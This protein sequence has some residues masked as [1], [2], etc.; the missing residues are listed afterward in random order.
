MSIVN[1]NGQGGRGPGA[2]LPGFPKT[3]FMYQGRRRP[4]KVGIRKDIEAALGDAVDAQTA[5]PSAEALRR[6]RLLPGQPA[7]RS[8]ADRP[9]RRTCR[10]GHRGRVAE[11]QEGHR[12]AQ[13][14]EEGK[15]EAASAKARTPSLLC[16]RRPGS[17]GRWPRLGLGVG[18]GMN[19]PEK[20]ETF[21][22]D[23]LDLPKAL[24]PLKAKPNWVTWK[25]K[26]VGADKKTGEDKWTK[27]PCQPDGGVAAKTDDP[28]TWGSYEACVRTVKRGKVDGIG[29][30][31]L[32][33]GFAAFDVDKCRD[34]A[35]GD[36]RPYAQELL[37]RCGDTY[38]E[39][40]VSGT[41]IRII[42]SSDE[43]DE[44]HKKY[45]VGDGV[46]VELY[47]KATRYITVSGSVLPGHDGG[48]KNIDAQID[49]VHAEC[50]ARKKQQEQ[51]E[52]TKKQ[53]KPAEDQEPLTDLLEIEH[54]GAGVQHGKYSSRNA[55]LFGFLTKSIRKKVDDQVMID[56]CLDPKYQGKAIYEHCLENGGAKY[57]R[58]QIERAKKTVSDSFEMG[59]GN[60]PKEKSQHN[61]KLALAK[62]NVSLRYDEF[63]DS[64]LIDGLKGHVKMIDAAVDKLWLLIDENFGMLPPKDLFR[65]VLVT[66]ARENSFHPVRDYLN[67]L[68]WDGTDAARQLADHVLRGE[69]NGLHQ[70]RR[71]DRPGRRGPQDREAR[72]QVRRDADPR[73]PT[74]RR[75]VD[76]AEDVGRQAGVV[77]RRSAVERRQQEDHRATSRQVDIGSRRDGRHTED[78]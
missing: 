39:V 4:L 55:I 42:G 51:Q 71:Q 8:G 37:R 13:G 36:L 69:G 2:A 50:E 46:S 63:N 67:S 17:G 49:E 30:C 21:H 70:G 72:V 12:R 19:I 26:Y 14:Q 64:M 61:V 59:K 53:K 11:R 77:H 65:P 24:E 5:S 10:R 47:R 57:V 23:L 9:A 62:L 34:P 56:A 40:T 41:G 75:Q 58:S 60:V 43:K 27:V 32:G 28:K 22:V 76:P 66:L 45:P 31:L 54:L 3:F 15:A 73:G 38:A 48:L 18:V 6:Q 33:S 20:P 68:K 25:W 52:Q 1:D 29:F 16:G 44:T 7:G 74:G 78:H 35:T